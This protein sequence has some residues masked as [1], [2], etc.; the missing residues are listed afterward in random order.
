MLFR[1]ASKP[2]KRPDLDLVIDQDLC[3]SCGA[4]VAVCPPDALFLHDIR[5]TVD[6]DVC[7]DCDRCVAMCPVHALSLVP[8]SGRI[9]S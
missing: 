2:T 5:L 6:Q 8:H 9:A 3:Y 4:C 7:T 1:R